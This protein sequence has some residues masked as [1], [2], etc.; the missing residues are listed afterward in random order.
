VLS[1]LPAP[2]L[3]SF[4]STLQVAEKRV[5]D[6]LPVGRNLRDEYIWSRI[7]APLEEYI[8]EGRLALTQFCP[9]SSLVSEQDISNSQEQQHPASIFAFLYTLTL[10]I[11]K[12]EIIL[13]R[14]PL[15]FGSSSLTGSGSSSPLPSIN[16]PSSLNQNDPLVCFLPAL[17]N[18]WHVLVTKL[19]NLVNQNGRVLSAEMVRT[20]FKQ[21]DSLVDVDIAGIYMPTSQPFA[22]E[23]DASSVG[24]KATEAIRERFIKELGWLVGIRTPAFSMNTQGNQVQGGIQAVANQFMDSRMMM[25]EN[26][27][28]D[29]EL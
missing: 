3:E 25:T 9:S 2:S 11:R 22:N 16:N 7:R 6:A 15:P 23:N 19:S 8:A 13:P 10:S 5:L 26:D 28:S 12:L 29:E 20:W 24:R 27:E 17:I 14:A 4:T 1:L 18:Q 21:L